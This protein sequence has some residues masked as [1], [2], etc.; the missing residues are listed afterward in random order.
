[1]ESL[2]Y[3]TFLYKAL[4]NKAQ[5][6]LSKYNNRKYPASY[7]EVLAICLFKDGIVQGIVR[8]FC[9]ATLHLILPLDIDNII[10][11]IENWRKGEVNGKTF[12]LNSHTVYSKEP[13]LKGVI[14]ID[15]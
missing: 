9:H 15:E 1:V 2:I 13:S 3:D 11:A 10:Y 8:I 5:L 14:N 6:L 12:F 4:L 7:S